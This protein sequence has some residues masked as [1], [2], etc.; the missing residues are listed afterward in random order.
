VLG[1]EMLPIGEVAHRAG[2]APSALRYYERV[3]LVDAARSAGGQRRYPR[4]V[5]PPAR[6]HPGGAERRPFPGR[7]QVSTGNAAGGPYSYGR[8]LEPDVAHPGEA[9][10]TPRSR[11]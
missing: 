2:I 8:R 4:S 1:A 9:A 10:S 6:V 7:D 3:G 11:G 5:L